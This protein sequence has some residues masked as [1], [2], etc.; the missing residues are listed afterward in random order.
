MAL[1]RI[2]L[3]NGGR[4]VSGSVGYDQSLEYFRAKLEN[5]GYSVAKQEF[6]ITT[7]F[8]VAAPVV[9]EVSPMTGTSLENFILTYSGSGDVTA[10]VTVPANLGCNP[11]DFAGFPAGNIALIA[12]GTCT[13]TVKANNAVAA[14]ARAIV[15][16]NNA[17]GILTN[18]NVT[19]SFT[20][21]VPVVI[22]SQSSGQELAAKPGLRMRVKTEVFRG[23]AK[24]ANLIAESKAGDPNTVVMAGANLDS[25]YLSPGIQAN[26]SG[27]AALL[28][29][30][31]LLG[32]VTPRNQMRF[33]W[34]A[35]QK[36][37]GTS[38]GTGGFLG[39][40]HYLSQLGQSD[41]DKI[42]LYLNFDSI[43]A[44]NFVYFVTDGDNSDG[45]GS[46]AGPEGS[47]AVEA[48][49]RGFYTA[50]GIPVKS[51]DL[52]PRSDYWPFLSVGI[53]ASGLFT[54]ANGGDQVK[55]A[56]EAAIWGGTAGAAYDA[57]A[58]QPCDTLT[59]VN[60]AALEVNSDAVAYA[61]LQSAMHAQSWAACPRVKGNFQ[62]EEAAGELQ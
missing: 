58:G 42:S 43:A 24:T 49:L 23:E 55:T 44:P 61:V 34:W 13:F 1:E 5:A 4:R 6:N 60:L 48:I 29:T 59:N 30:A 8:P 37:A 18:G 20:A 45:V 3:A 51:S 35:E 40:K 19:S 57:C 39:A 14:G 21:N 32:K 9:A 56:Q 25:N 22:V 17:P 41:L 11:V 10:N 28:E 52:D 53:P 27:A 50:R 36:L 54:G 7:W 33:A 2:A 15:F 47:G 26:G 38:G 12:R 46:P 62:V 16:F 31:L